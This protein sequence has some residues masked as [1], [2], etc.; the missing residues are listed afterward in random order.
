MLIIN[1]HP[2]LTCTL[3]NTNY[4][5]KKLKQCSRL[6][7]HVYQVKDDVLIC[8]TKNELIITIEGTDTLVNWYDNIS[9]GLRKN[10][11]HRGF[12]RYSTHC[13]RKYNLRTILEETNK[14]IYVCGHSLGAAAAIV[15]LFKLAFLLKYKDCT[16]VLFGSPKPGGKQFTEKFNNALPYL[17]IYN[18]Q[19][20]N[21]LVCKL[22][23]DFL[24]YCHINEDDILSVNK[25]YNPIHVLKN[26]S[27]DNYID[28]I[29]NLNKN[30]QI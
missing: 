3:E 23:F 8:E 16:L 17:N 26:H 22:P 24:G 20:K 2:F 28:N 18:F 30:K 4:R 25:I 13:I 15:I 7:K 12:F 5:N 29:Y 27:M 9:I 14:P 19:N 11:I 1:T 21:D 10:D 6:A